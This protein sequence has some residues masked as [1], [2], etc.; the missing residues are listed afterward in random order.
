MANKTLWIS[1]LDGTLLNKEK[2]VS[3]YTKKILNEKI[4]E[5]LCFSIAT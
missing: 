4:A 3:D 2:K 1:D 5:G